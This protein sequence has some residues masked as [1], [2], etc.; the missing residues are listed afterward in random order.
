MKR[1]SEKQLHRKIA[2]ERI[3]GLF[4]R[5]DETKDPKLANRYAQLARKIQMR[6]KV[7]MPD[8]VRYR[9][10]KKCGSFWKP[11][12]TVRI[13][14]REGKVIFTCLVCGSMRKK[15]SWKKV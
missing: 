5:A 7:R 2:V 11:G 10:C 12:T 15:P 13:R 1:P 8:E 6:F 4:A 9:F 3:L 14:T